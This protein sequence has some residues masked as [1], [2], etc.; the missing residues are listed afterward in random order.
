MSRKHYQM[1]AQVLN[2]ARCDWADGQTIDTLAEDFADE[3]VA[4]NERFDRERFLKACGVG[5]E[6]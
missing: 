2:T 1:I 4:T 6:S 5:D 3:L